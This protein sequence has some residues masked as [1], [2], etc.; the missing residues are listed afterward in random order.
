MQC[1]AL[2]TETG[3]EFGGATIEYATEEIRWEW[4]VGDEGEQ[5]EAVCWLRGVD[6]VL[7]IYLCSCFVSYY[8]QLFI[9]CFL[10]SCINNKKFDRKRQRLKCL[11]TVKLCSHLPF[12]AL[13][14]N[15]CNLSQ[16]IHTII[17]VL[18]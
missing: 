18:Q 16:Q 12:C 13:Q 6:V 7:E 14:F 1:R 2:E 9:Q 5:V 17:L 15:Y 10:S 11:R 4:R 8:T 3:H